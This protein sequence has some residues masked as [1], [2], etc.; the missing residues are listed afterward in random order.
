M[1]ACSI[2]VPNFRRTFVPLEHDTPD[3][4]GHVYLER[5]WPNANA[6]ADLGELFGSFEYLDLDIWVFRQSHG[7]RQA[8]DTSAAVS[9]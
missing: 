2:P 1:S 4:G 8:T 6:G 3:S 9:A 7:E 5:T